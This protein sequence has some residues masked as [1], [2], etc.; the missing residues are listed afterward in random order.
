MRIA[1]FSAREH[2]VQSLTHEVKVSQIDDEFIFLSERLKLN[3]AILAQNCEGVLLFVSDSA[4]APILSKLHELGV[5]VIFLRCAGFDQ[6]DLGAAKR[7]GLPVLRIPSYSPHAV[8]EHAV[9]LLMSLNRHTHRAYNRTREF[10]FSLNAL[11]GF[12][13]HTKTIGVIGTGKIGF[14]FAQ[15]LRCGFG[16]RV[17]AFDV[18]ENEQ[19]AAIGVE[20][21]SLD[22]IFKEADIISLHCPLTPDTRHIIDQNAISKM[23]KGVIIINS[24]RG[25]LIDTRALVNGLKSKWIGGAGLDVFE[26]EEEYFYGDHSSEFIAD[27]M[28]AR[29]VTFPNVL[30][31]GHQAF[32]TKEA[33]ETIAK[34]TMENIK[35]YKEKE[36]LTNQ[37]V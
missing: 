21:H 9:A 16:A 13:V 32:F 8:A 27:D 33:L 35:A 31:T 14:L 24:S 30:I 7:L 18:K 36:P 19:A 4:S 12:D 3:T 34:L 28:L 25:G 29:L 17:L 11:L 15:I 23:K 20:Y 6:V 22:N 26:G 37:L 5:R 1:V 2:D 10:N